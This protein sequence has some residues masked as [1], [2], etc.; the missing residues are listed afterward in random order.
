MDFTYEARNMQAGVLVQ[1]E[2]T[3]ADTKAALAAI[4][5]Q[6]LLV[7]KLEEKKRPLTLEGLIRGFQKVSAYELA[8]FS[9]EFET[10]IG[11]GM[12]IVRTLS[13]LE[14]QTTNHV[15]KEN[16]IQIRADVEAGSSLSDALREHPKTFNELY[17]NMVQMG[18]VTGQLDVALLRIADYLEKDYM[19]RKEVKSAT[20]YPMVVLG[21]GLIAMLGLIT[22]I[23][24]RFVGIYHSLSPNADLPL[25]TAILQQIGSFITHQFYI[26]IPLVIG[27]VF[28]IK[29]LFSLPEVRHR[30]DKIKLR[31][32]L[33]LGT[34]V[35]QVIFA[36][37]SRTFAT[38][39]ATGVP[40]MQALDIAASTA[41]NVV[42]RDEFLS[43]KEKVRQGSTLAKPIRQSK[44]FPPMF[45]AMVASGEESGKMDVILTKVAEFYEAE[46]EAALKSLKSIIE[47]LLIIVVGVMIGTI[48]IGMYLPIFKVYQLIK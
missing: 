20:R 10:M 27:A 45:S 40:L 4:K 32:P 28:G 13:V 47:P 18:E 7:I 48:V 24:P 33:R 26:F 46:V 25:L 23:L 42:I 8:L 6:G 1:G 16:L 34:L 39:L 35:K 44:I 12:S 2:I 14:E 11:S 38:L 29:K 22:F 5:Q 9:R 43:L 15:F 19:L 36:R 17:V 31:L 3:A 30:W 37:V 41:N 21:F